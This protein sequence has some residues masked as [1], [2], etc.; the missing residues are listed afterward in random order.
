MASQE[1][2]AVHNLADLK[3]TSDDAIPNYLNSLG[4]RQDHRLADTRL[5]LG[6]GAFAVAAACFLW[7]YRLGFERTKLYTAAAVAL[8]SLLNGALTYWI[9]LV[10]RGTVYQGTAPDG[11]KISIA[12]STKKNV[13]VYH[14]QITVTPPPKGT[15]SSSPPP[16]P[17]ELARPFTEW[18]DAQG[19]FVARPFQAMLVAAVPAVAQADPKRAAELAEAETT[20]TTSPSDFADADPELLDALLAGSAGNDPGATPAIATATG[21]GVASKKGKRRKA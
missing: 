17:I 16:Q 2:I 20:S 3:N 9:G 13:P 18:F 12:T 10:E 6:Y 21:A 1:R 15:S 4:F 19:H 14:A 5:A 11:T 7:D 8:Y